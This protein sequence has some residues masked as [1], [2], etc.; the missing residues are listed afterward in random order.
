MISPYVGQETKQCCTQ[1]VAL[2]RAAPSFH[3][4]TH[5]VHSAQS[6]YL[7][8]LLVPVSSK[9]LYIYRFSMQELET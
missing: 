8:L 5:E 4:Y 1:Q 2:N 7:A 9:R 6:T 3:I